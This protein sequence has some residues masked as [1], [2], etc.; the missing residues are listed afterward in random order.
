MYVSE[1]EKL[2]ALDIVQ[3]LRLNGIVTETNNLNKSLKGQF[4]EADR[5]SAKYLI[6]LNNEDLK[7][8]LVNV[9]D[10]RTKEEEKVDIAEL[11]E[12]IIGNL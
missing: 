4:K 1:E 12:Y 9:K 6:I 7:K 5:L 3:N 11:T 10:N 8:G 2:Y